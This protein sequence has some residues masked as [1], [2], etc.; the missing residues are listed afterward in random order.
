[1]KVAIAFAINALCNFIIGLWVAKFLGPEA[2]GR[3]ALALA[4]G[5][6]IQ[7]ACFDWI[8]LAA[9]RFAATRSGQI[10]TH[11]RATLDASFASV[12][13]AVTVLG[14]GALLGGFNLSLSPELL[15]LA[16]LAA[17]V[18]GYFDYQQAL[19]R[20]RF[21]DGLYARLLL[22]K[23]LLSA[24][25]TVGGA[26][27][28]GSAIVAVAGVCL[29]MA[30]S[31]ASAHRALR[32]RGSDRDPDS[33]GRALD[34]LR[35]AKPVV[36]ANLLY[37][38]LALLNR[39]L[40]VER[41][42]FAE[43]GQFSLAFDMG[44]RI[45]QSLGVMLDVVLFQLA[46]RADARHGGEIAQAQVSR[47]MGLAFALL[48]PACLGL[49]LVLPSLEQIAVP[50]AFRGHFERYFTLL[51]PGFLCFGLSAYAI[52]PIF[53]I[54]RRTGPLILAALAAC[55]GDLALLALLPPGADSI[56]L[57]QTGAMGCG[58]LALILF[59]L[60]P[61]ARWPLAPDLLAP[62]FGAGFMAAAL[63]PLRDWE[64]GAGTL[65][66]QILAGAAL[67]G[68][69]LWAFDACGLRTAAHAL[70]RDRRKAP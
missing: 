68:T 13:L 29:A 23:N 27:L 7:I 39:S 70:W 35:Y 33:H 58:L 24:V 5:V 54:A 59:A 41:H 18:N 20:A 11:A 61:P 51:L 65:I 52:A 28:T 64:P 30:G 21:E 31:L 3:F 15:G 47:N 2:F 53:Q 6:V 45:T 55:A 56:A 8:R 32:R 22:T 40:M 36:A 57:A 9:A 16:L 44:Q 60:A 1:M 34:F 49:W 69:T 66:A 12:T 62:L 26:W 38:A 37:L 19:V 4:V 67:Y 14:L 46:V 25:L 50:T 63:A 17:V 48:T 43:A 10:G 42:G